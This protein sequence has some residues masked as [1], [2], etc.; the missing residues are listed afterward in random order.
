MIKA[1]TD[2]QPPPS[3]SSTP[4]S[5]SSS[6]PGSGSYSPSSSFSIASVAFSASSSSSV[7]LEKSLGVYEFFVLLAKESFSIGFLFIFY[8]WF[9]PFLF[10]S[11]IKKYIDI[12]G[13]ISTSLAITEGLQSWP[14]QAMHNKWRVLSNHLKVRR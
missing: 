6:R 7:V 10:F 5:S 8:C 14:V 13:D 4:S 1:I 3:S 11:Q 9:F 12:T 2:Y